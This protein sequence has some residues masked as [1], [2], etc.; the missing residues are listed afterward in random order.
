MVTFTSVMNKLKAVPTYPTFVRHLNGDTQDNR[1][2]NLAFVTLREAFHHMAWR[3]D[4]VCYLT[5][6]EVRFTKNLLS[7]CRAVVN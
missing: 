6:E 1:A 3:V 2:T 5:E 4:W 7:C